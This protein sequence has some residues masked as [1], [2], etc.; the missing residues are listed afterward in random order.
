MS[1]FEVV[2]LLTTKCKSVVEARDEEDAVEEFWHLLD[3]ENDAALE[4]CDVVEVNE[5]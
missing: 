1:R 3:E 4:E 5:M 2:A